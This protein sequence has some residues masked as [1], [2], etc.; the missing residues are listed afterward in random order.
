MKKEDNNYLNKKRKSNDEKGKFNMKGK[1]EFSN[2]KRLPCQFYVNGA[3]HKGNEC[4]YSHEIGQVQKN[5][6]YINSG[7]M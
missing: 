1:K 2:Y 7:I 6:T 5:V 4:T 3:C